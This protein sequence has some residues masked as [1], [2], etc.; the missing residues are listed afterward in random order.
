VARLGDDQEVTADAVGVGIAGIVRSGRVLSAS[1]LG[2]KG[3]D[4]RAELEGRLLLPV[5]VV[6]DTQA[7][8]LAELSTADE[9]ETAVFLSVGTGIGGAVVHDGRLFSGR[10]AAGDFGHMQLAVDGPRCVCGARGCLEQLASGRV[11]N[12]VAVEL[13]ASGRSP[14]LESRGASTEAVHAGDLD[15]AARDGDEAAIEA[16]RRA[17]AALVAGLRCLAAAYDPDRIVLGGGLLD[18]GGYLLGLVTDGW[19]RERPS[20]TTA[21]LALA[22]HGED[23]GLLGAALLWIS[24]VVT[25]SQGPEDKGRSRT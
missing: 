3:L 6:N 25:S 24:P 18:E 12:T 15:E 17:S 22:R 4:L 23:A 19:I 7:V 8:A 20:W 21:E 11:L 10:G 16:L 1:N 2:L 5:R 14:L 13:A 9:G